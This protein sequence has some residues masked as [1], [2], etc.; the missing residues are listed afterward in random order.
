MNVLFAQTNFNRLP[1]FRVQTSIK[2]TPKGKIVEKKAISKEAY[3]HIADLETN[4]Q[5]LL[6]SKSVFSVPKILKSNEQS[7]IYEYIDGIN[8]QVELELA[9]FRKNYDLA[10]KLVQEFISF[11]LSF[12]KDMV[13]N[14]QLT[15]FA[16]LF[17]LPFNDFSK[18]GTEIEAFLPGLLDLKMSNFIRAEK[19]NMFLVDHEWIYDTAVPVKFILWR[20]LFNLL[21]SLQQLIQYA[22]AVEYPS[23]QLSDLHLCPVSWWNMFNFSVSE[24]KVFAGWESQFQTMVTGEAFSVKNVIYSDIASLNN[25]EEVCSFYLASTQV[26]QLLD[27]QNTLD[28]IA[29]TQEQISSLEN[30]LSRIQFAKFYKLWQLY[31][32]LKIIGQ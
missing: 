29:K 25:V 3:R 15:Q 32:T 26:P 30:D 9:L 18:F 13:R 19:K 17:S 16:D 27:L 20:V 31:N 12:P 6:N 10:D 28:E 24:Y 4:Y 14:T 22:T 8:L 2:K 21:T 1:Q 5:L 11:I 23:Y 7:I